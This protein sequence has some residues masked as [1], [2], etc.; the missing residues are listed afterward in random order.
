MRCLF[1]SSN[2]KDNTA[3][4]NEGVNADAVSEARTGTGAAAVVTLLV[5]VASVRG[6][7]GVF[8]VE[9]I[10]DF[11]F[12]LVGVFGAETTAA[13][14]VEMGRLAERVTGMILNVQDES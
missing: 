4:R 8:G 3:G 12:R 9:G 14:A 13:T 11:A 1:A 5:F 2:E 10:S 7:L 6:F